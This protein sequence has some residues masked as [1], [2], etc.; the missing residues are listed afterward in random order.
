ML[1]LKEIGLRVASLREMCEISATEMAEK[2]EIS[3]DDYIAFEHGE[4]DFAI[5][6]LNNIALILGVDILDII[7]GESPRL[8]TCTVV[9]K[10]KGFV[11]NR[12]PG[13]E[14]SH[15][16]YTFKDKKAEPFLVTIEPNGNPPVMDE[17]EGQ[18]F[19]YVLSG[20]MMLYI[21][22]ICY[23]LNEGDSAYFNSTIPHAHKVIGESP[24]QFIALVLK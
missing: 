24:A 10:G 22:D 13:Y 16:A 19:D 11:V 15:L 8:S 6:T 7:S 4:Y 2:L 14:F 20:Q 17:H 23:E 12:N 21:G 1:E 18:E 5:S 3:E 9:K